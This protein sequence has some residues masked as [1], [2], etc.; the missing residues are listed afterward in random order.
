MEARGACG[1]I[2]GQVGSMFSGCSSSSLLPHVPGATRSGGARGWCRPA[3]AHAHC[4]HAHSCVGG[5]PGGLQPRGPSLPTGSAT[6]PTK[7]ASESFP[8]LTGTKQTLQTGCEGFLGN[9]QKA[10]GSGDGGNW[11]E[12]DGW[13]HPQ[14]YAS[15]APFK[16]AR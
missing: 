15:M 6:T 5:R 9:P 3:C 11:R 10:V 13:C 16:I 7:L 14:L 1:A 2:G 12:G 8:G 4:V